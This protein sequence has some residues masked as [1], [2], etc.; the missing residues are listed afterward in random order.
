MIQRNVFVALVLGVALCGSPSARP[1][2]AEV[3]RND[4]PEVTDVQVTSTRIQLPPSSA[5]QAPKITG[6]QYAVRMV[7]RRYQHSA[8]RCTTAIPDKWADYIEAV[9]GF[10]KVANEIAKPLLS[11]DEF[12]AL[13]SATVPQSIADGIKRPLYFDDV[14]APNHVEGICAGIMTSLLN[15]STES[16]T[17]ELTQSLISTKSLVMRTR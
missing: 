14:W 9:A 16:L 17:Y 12:S 15:P 11:S 5:E 7:I 13:T 3:D 1:A 2:S 10:V 8:E 4:D 6:A